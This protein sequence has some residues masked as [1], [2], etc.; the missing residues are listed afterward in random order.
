LA[1]L[2][3]Q[4]AIAPGER[5]EA[6]QENLANRIAAL[7][8]QLIRCAK[9]LTRD[10][11]KAEDLVQTVILRALGKQHF[12]RE[13]GE[14]YGWLS[15]MMR[16]EWVDAIRKSARENLVFL[17]PNSATLLHAAALA[18][19]QYH[20]VLY[21]EVR[22]AIDALPTEQKEVVLM[23]RV[24]GVPL[25]EVAKL[26]G[27]PTGTIRSRLYRGCARIGRTLEI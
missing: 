4:E 24:D 23:C 7:R 9:A 15:T 22:R 20:A 11:V 26:R 25:V 19:V 3:T 12:Y 6:L 10:P 16:R 1:A 27:L 8:P 17:E 5:Q 18:E 2:K 21:R 14:L 13:K